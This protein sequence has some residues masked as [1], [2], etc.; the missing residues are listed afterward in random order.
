MEGGG[1]KEFTEAHGGDDDGSD[2]T[3]TWSFLLPTEIKEHRH[4]VVLVVSIAQFVYPPTPAV[5]SA[6][7][8][9]FCNEILSSLREKI[10]SV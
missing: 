9:K 10:T 3:T 1:K 6:V 5:S 8:D 4:L 7:H 2:N